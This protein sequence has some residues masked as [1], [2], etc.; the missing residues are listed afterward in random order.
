MRF[1]SIGSGSDGNGTLIR[2]SDGECVLLDCGF[3]ARDAL[4][5]MAEL[6]VCGE[7]LTAILVTHEHSDHVKGVA[8]LANRCRVPV[9]ATWGTWRAKLEAQLDSALFRQITP[10][11]KLSSIP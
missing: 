9:Y 10:Q 4:A 2:G 7:D 1:A 3:S 8:R 11:S 6:D 5:R